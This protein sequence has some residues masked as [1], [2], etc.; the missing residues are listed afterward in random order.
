MLV[1]VNCIVAE[2][3]LSGSA[4]PSCVT[5]H[6]RFKTKPTTRPGY[7]DLLDDKKNGGK[8]HPKPP[9]VIIIRP[10]TLCLVSFPLDH[11]ER[12]VVWPGYL[13]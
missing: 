12:S 5:G 7:S 1:L 10:A 11:S 2:N 9:P 13:F 4:S 3:N 6:P 8:C